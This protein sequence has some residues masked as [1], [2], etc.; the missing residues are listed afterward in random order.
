[1]RPP[2][3]RFGLGAAL[4]TPFEPDGRVDTVR[5]V[6]HAR[7]CLAAGCSSVTLFG[8]TGEGASLGFAERSRML[9][10]MLA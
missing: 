6:A 5:L 10:A 2:A 3:D 7:R 8:T 9:D 1:M 4:I